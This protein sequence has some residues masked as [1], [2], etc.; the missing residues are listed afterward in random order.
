MG[1]GFR[2]LIGQAVAAGQPVVTYV[3][4]QQQAAFLQFADGLDERLDPRNLA[5]W[6]LARFA[7]AS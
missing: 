3:P 5:R 2:D 6:C 1:R 4:R 7:E